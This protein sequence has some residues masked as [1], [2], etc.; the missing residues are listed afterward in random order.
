V[1][2][3]LGFFGAVLWNYVET[4]RE[5]QNIRKALGYYVPSEVVQQLARNIADIKKGGQTVYGACLF[6]DAAGYTKVAEKMGPR[7][8]SDFMHTYFEALFEPIRQNGGLVIGMEGDSILAIWKAA[9]PE[10]ALR[11]QACRAAL[12]VARAV[13]KFN[14]AFDELKLPTRVGAHAGPIFLGHI[15]AGEHYRYGVT[16]DTVNT[17]SRLDGLNKYLGTEILVSEEIIRGLS[18][19]IAREAGSFLLKGKAQPVIVYELLGLAEEC[20]ENQARVCE[21]FSE[22]LRAFRQQS[23]DKAKEKFQES[24]SSLAEDRLSKFYLKLCSEYETSPPGKSWAGVI[25]LEEK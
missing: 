5:R 15:G 11:Q 7:E 20:R 24:V 3:P 13:N 8:L 1:Q 21:I 22:G 6:T 19:F 23:W 10:A 17:A 4:N 9:R 2:A 14:R 18:G 12:G 16:G 25:P